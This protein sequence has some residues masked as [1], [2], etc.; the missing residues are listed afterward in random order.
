MNGEKESR[1]ADI[2]NREGEIEVENEEVLRAL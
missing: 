2:K 1:G